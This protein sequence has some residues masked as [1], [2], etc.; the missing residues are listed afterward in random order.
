[1]TRQ[2]Y[3]YVG[4]RADE[5][6]AVGMAGHIWGWK[7]F[8]NGGQKVDEARA[9]LSEPDLTESTWLIFVRGIRAA[10]PVPSGWPR[11]RPE[12][13]GAWT[14]AT[15]QTVTCRLL[16]APLHEDHVRQVWRDDQYP[17]RVNLDPETEEDLG[18]IRAADIAEDALRAIRHSAVQK[19]W[20][21]LGPPL[22][23]A[24]SVAPD[25][26]IPAGAGRETVMRVIPLERNRTVT[27]ERRPGES[28]TAVRREAGLVERYKAYLERHGLRAV[29][30]E[31]TLPGRLDTFFTDVYV[32]DVEELLEAK[33]SSRR[34]HIRLA[35]GQLCDYGRFVAPRSRA[36]LLPSRPEQDLI[37]LLATQNISCVYEAEEGHFIR[38]DAAEEAAKGAGSGG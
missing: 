14:G 4:D 25:R 22:F 21:I 6:F 19:G 18:P 32:E 33:A 38:E 31:I 37:D 10:P 17:Y 5:N 35:I 2:A 29:R 23:R 27:F 1:M 15:I 11:T 3:I 13:F 28:V 9:W 36:V 26:H 30:N 12:D 16:A 8:A 34:E 20:P 24:N 7:T